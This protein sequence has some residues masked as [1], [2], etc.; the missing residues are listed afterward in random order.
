MP[1]PIRLGMMISIFL[2]FPLLPLD[3]VG[4]VG[5]DDVVVGEPGIEE[6]RL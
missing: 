3:C 4:F 2:Y 6:S 1:A 5:E